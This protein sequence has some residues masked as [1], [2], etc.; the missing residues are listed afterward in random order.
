M[1]GRL[2]PGTEGTPRRFTRFWTSAWP[3]WGLALFAGLA[4]VRL[5][6]ESYARTALAASI[7]FM[8]PGS[9]TLGAIF[10]RRRRPKGIEFVCY[11]ALL[12]A[13]WSA[14]ASL[15]LYAC[16]LLI[17][18]DNTYWCLLIISAVLAIVAEAR[19]LLGRP[20]GGHRT[21]AK[22]ETLDP[23]LSEAEVDDKEML[24]TSKDWRSSTVL[25]VIAG[26]SLLGGGLY[27]YD[28]LPHPKP[29]GYTWIAWTG[30]PKNGTIPV[31]SAG[32]ELRF[33]IVHH[34]SD[35]AEFRLSATWLVT[36]SRP[37]A[38]PVTF[39]IGPNQTFHGTLFVPSPPTGCTYRIVVALTAVR[40]V[41][42]LTKKP[43]TWSINADV[44]NSSK[45]TKTCK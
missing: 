39:S 33:Q 32:T 27:A 38:K 7:L 24:A 45:S 20:A 4:A 6:P 21:V 9:L 1:T 43:Q 2:E 30:T 8:V 13:V 40:Q 29:T 42:P 10:S 15:A 44:Y 19:T 23:D 25:A 11:A 5:L 3:L 26:V 16:G 31:G 35:R 12:G 17:T 28:H 22:A 41:D 36:P 34:Q 18:A 37:L 14:F